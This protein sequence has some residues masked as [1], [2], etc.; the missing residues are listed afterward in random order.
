MVKA[1]TGNPRTPMR[2]TRPRASSRERRRSR[3]AN[4]DEAR[5]VESH[6]RTAR[7]PASRR[8]RG[9][10]R[11]RSFAA[12]RRFFEALAEENPAVLVFED[13]PL[14]RRTPA[15]LLRRLSSSTGRAACRDS[16]SRGT[17]RPELLVRRSDWGGGKPNAVTAS[18][19]PLSDQETALLLA[20]NSSSRPFAG[21]VAVDAPRPGRW[22]DCLRRGVRRM[23]AER[24]RREGTTSWRFPRLWAAS[25]QRVR[26]ARSRGEGRPAGL[27]GGRPRVWL[28]AATHLGKN[29]SALDDPLA[30]PS[31]RTK[32]VRNP[33][34]AP[35]DSRRRDRVRVPPPPRP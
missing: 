30:P 25:S 3:W 4:E 35:L 2:P 8:A 17:A 7:R 24:S 34:P 16:P 20:R 11:A 33:A 13:L 21:G 32:T 14:G 9:D 22:G 23:L 1:H 6:P 29:R 27:I 5:W 19:A 12:W 31:A 18:L 28:G 10:D 26:H 15:R